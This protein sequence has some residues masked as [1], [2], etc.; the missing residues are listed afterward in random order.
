MTETF[1]AAAERGAATV[2]LTVWEQNPRAIAF[3]RKVGFADAGLM[4]FHLGN[5]E[6][7]DFLMVKAL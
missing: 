5:E 7:T 4:S 2:W 6:Q 3:Y 1:K